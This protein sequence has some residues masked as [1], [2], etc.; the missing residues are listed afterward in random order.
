MS[1]RNTAIFADQIDDLALG[2]GLKKNTSED[3]KMEIAIKTA[4]GLKFDTAELAIE[5]DDFAG[6][7]LSDDGSDNLKVNVDNSTIE[8]DTDTLRVKDEGIT[9][10]KLGISNTPTDGYYLKYT[11]ANGMT[12]ADVD[13]DSVQED[14]FVFHEIPSGS[15]DSTNVTFTLANTPVSG[16]VQVFLNGLLQAPGSGLDYTISGIT[17]TFN[18]APHTGSDLYVHYLIT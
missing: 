16:T 4:S 7:G 3:T 13:A 18:K 11:T 8:I 15:I 17:I 12:W 1:E 9:E 5:P 14:D 10:S 2:D 6:D